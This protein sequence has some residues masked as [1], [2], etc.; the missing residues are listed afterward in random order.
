MF[1]QEEIDAVLR[2]AQAAVDDLSNDVQGLGTQSAT[3]ATATSSHSP[4]QGKSTGSAAA[5]KG[6]RPSRRVERILRLRVP[7][8]VRVAQRQMALGEILKI[9]PGT[10]L[11]FDRDVEEHLDLMVN[12]HQIGSGVAVK[13]N[14][15]FGIR[16]TKIR[17]L[18]SRI[19]SLRQ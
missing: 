18:K 2:D 14:E 9:A 8:K 17:N 10:I 5:R 11:E 12:N 6:G 4:A 7:V 13:V 16:I 3:A 19:D 1:S 15:S